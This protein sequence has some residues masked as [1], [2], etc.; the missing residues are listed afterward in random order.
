MR[1]SREVKNTRPVGLPY[2]DG[3]RFLVMILACG[4]VAG[5]CSSARPTRFR[6]GDVRVVERTPGGVVLRFG[7]SVDN[8]GEDP[9]PFREVIYGVMLDGKEVFRGRRSAEMTLR[10][11]GTQ[12]LVLPAAIPAAEATALMDGESG[13]TVSY[14][15]LGDVTYIKPGVLSRTLFD[16]D[17]VRPS[18]SFTVSGEVVVP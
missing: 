5:G 8:P 6:A 7:I 17:V 13:R 9:L 3:M 12:E 10:R 15:I 16:A 11:F 4:V 1:D 14:T 18:V 2:S